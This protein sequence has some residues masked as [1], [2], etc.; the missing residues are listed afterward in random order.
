VRP[1][2]SLSVF[3]L[4]LVVVFGSALGLGDAVGPVA[5]SEPTGPKGHA[6]MEDAHV[7]HA[8]STPAGLAI[9]DS[10]WTLRPADATLAAGRD[11]PYRF[12]IEGPD[13]APESSYRQTHTKDLHLVV[14][15]RD[16]STFQHVHPTRAADGTWSAPLAL[17][18]GVYRVLADVRPAAADHQLVLGADLLVPGELEPVDLPA[19]R[20]TTVTTDGYTVTLHGTPVA[21]HESDLVLSVSRGGRPVT[22]LQPYLGAYGHLVALRTGDLAYLHTHPAG[23]AGDDTGGPD[24]AFA[25]TFPTA[26]TY[27]LFLDFRAR[28]VVRTAAFTVEARDG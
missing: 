16:L 9:S 11:V 21:G 6:A 24:I 19:S 25:T 8:A 7:S 26:G 5:R 22:T 27:R 14:V 1:A 3:G 17:D 18:A 10:G 12:T 13:G 23:D 15:R 28:G 20:R 4:G 2:T